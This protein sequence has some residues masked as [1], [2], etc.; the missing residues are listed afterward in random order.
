MC[1]ERWIEREQ[2]TDALRKA[3]Q[4]ADKIIEQ[5]KSPPAHPAPEP[6]QRPAVEHE[7]T[8]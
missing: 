2:V 4:E 6:E 8:A 1:Y 7:Q 5:A 3:R